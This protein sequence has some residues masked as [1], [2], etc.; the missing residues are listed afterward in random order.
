MDKILQIIGF[1]SLL[2]IA[3]I[4]GLMTNISFTFIGSEED[5]IAEINGTDNSPEIIDTLETENTP[6]INEIPDT[7]N[8]SEIKEPG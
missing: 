3:F 8:N 7:D 2:L 6:V 1:I 5:L 4:A